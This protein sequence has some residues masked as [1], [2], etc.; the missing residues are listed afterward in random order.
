MVY[1]M[2]GKLNTPRPS[3]V[4][5]TMSDWLA[6]LAL[7]CISCAVC[8]K[9]CDVDDAYERHPR[10]PAPPVVHEAYVRLDAPIAIHTR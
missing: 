9:L 8:C 10:E 5:C 6:A 3:S 1:K 7:T 2:A 4:P